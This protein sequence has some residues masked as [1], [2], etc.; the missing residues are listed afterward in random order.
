MV[1]FE[2]KTTGIFTAVDMKNRSARLAYWTIFTIV[3]IISISFF[4]P[5]FWMVVSSFKDTKEYLQVPPTL[6]P[7]S[8][9]LSKVSE[10]WNE[11]NYPK[12]YIP[13]HKMEYTNQ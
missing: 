7:K 12:Y 2:K 1:S 10:V 8:F 13:Q 6:F 11:L 4:L 5:P 3:L 9:N